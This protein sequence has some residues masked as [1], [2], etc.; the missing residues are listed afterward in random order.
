MA[1]EQLLLAKAGFCFSVSSNLS[2][3]QQRRQVIFLFL[4]YFPLIM[5]LLLASL[6]NLICA[7][8]QLQLCFCSISD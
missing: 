5:I 3:S 7:L 2:S 6:S 1:A 8:N 4:I